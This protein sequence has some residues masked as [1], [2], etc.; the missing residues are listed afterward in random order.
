MIL[1]FLNSWDITN[2]LLKNLKTICG[3]FQFWYIYSITERKVFPYI[4]FK[5][6]L[7]VLEHL[8]LLE[9]CVARVESTLVDLP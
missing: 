6:L 1:K 5:N 8:L 9:K 3:G 4:V 7:K 2:N